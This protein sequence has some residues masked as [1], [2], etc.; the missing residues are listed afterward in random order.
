MIRVNYVLFL[1][2][3]ELET[4]PPIRKENIKLAIIHSN[5]QHFCHLLGIFRRQMY[6]HVAS[7]P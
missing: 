6:H 5:I 3:M 4:W 7:D 1:H 2:G